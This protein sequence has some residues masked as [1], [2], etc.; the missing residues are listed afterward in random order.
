MRP[1]ANCHAQT[2]LLR[3]KAAGRRPF[4]ALCLRVMGTRPVAVLA[5]HGAEES[6]G[7]GGVFEANS[8]REALRLGLVL[9]LGYLGTRQGGWARVVCRR[10]VGAGAAGRDGV[11]HEGRVWGF[12]WA[13]GGWVVCVW[14][15]GVGRECVLVCSLRA[16][17]VKGKGGCEVSDGGSHLMMTTWYA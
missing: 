12:Y 2:R 6:A 5:Y 4:A 11:V 7:R 15:H 3:C 13:A 9:A 17:Y 14:F 1:P 10:V 16:C 8:V